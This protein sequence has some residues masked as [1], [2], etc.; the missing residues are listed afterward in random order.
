LDREQFDVICKKLDKIFAITAIQSIEAK[1]DKIYALKKFG[2]N[3]GEIAPLVGM[4]E[5]GIRDNPGWKKR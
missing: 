1:N 2:L 5:S 4:S 3:S